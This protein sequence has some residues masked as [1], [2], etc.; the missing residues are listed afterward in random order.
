MRD[1]ALPGPPPSSFQVS[2]PLSISLEI[3]N[4]QAL[5]PASLLE[6]SC[7]PHTVELLISLPKYL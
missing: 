4:Q 2:F 7:K 3:K 5:I 1:A 6:I